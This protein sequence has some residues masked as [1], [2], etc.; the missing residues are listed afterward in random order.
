MKLFSSILLILLLAFITCPNSFAQ[1]SSFG[2]PNI[3]DINSI[4]N[5][6]LIVIVEV[7][8]QRVLDKLKKKGKDNYIDAYYKAIDNYNN[9]M[10]DAVGKFWEFSKDVEYKTA[11]QV[12]S[13]TKLHTK[14]F[15]VLRCVSTWGNPNLG[16]GIS[17]S[18]LNWRYSD[19]KNP[20]PDETITW[21]D[22]SVM[23][24]S[25]I[26]NKYSGVCY[27]NLQ[28][29]FPLE[30]DMIYGLR[31]IQSTF[32]NKEDKIGSGQ[33]MSSVKQNA[34][35][36]KNKTLV[37]RNDLVDQE[38][39]TDD[40]K[41]IYPYNFEIADSVGYEN[42]FINADDGYAMLEVIPNYIGGGGM[43]ESTKIMYIFSVIDAKT[44]DYLG[45]VTPSTGASMGAEA[46][47]HEYENHNLNSSNHDVGTPVADKRLFK[48]LAAQAQGK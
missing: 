42:H 38:L 43:G 33:A 35:Q 10:K 12:D 13:I 2:G 48:Q 23:E 4:K 6:T 47:S 8:Q 15:A 40:I 26:E 37:I 17:I 34:L 44:G 18:G 9:N 22:F 11:E 46:R 32:K 14:D 27:I 39:K 36:L 16:G 25:L 41:N 20:Q 30:S 28:D 7:P 3:Q 21:R 24:I 1:L 45:F 29:F 19:I 31:S 5:R